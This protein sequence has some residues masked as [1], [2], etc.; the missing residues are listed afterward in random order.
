MAKLQ[1][2]IVLRD[3]QDIPF[4]E[5]NHAL[6]REF[7]SFYF[8]YAEMGNKLHFSVKGFKKMEGN[9]Y[10]TVLRI[11]DRFTPSMYA[12]IP[13]SFEAFS[14]VQDFDDLTG[15][16]F[17]KLVKVSFRKHGIQDKF[18]LLIPVKLSM[19][20]RNRRQNRISNISDE[21]FAHKFF[22]NSQIEAIYQ[23][24]PLLQKIFR[25]L[26]L[27][28]QKNFPSVEVDFIES[29]E[30][31][32]LELVKAMGQPFWEKDYAS[33]RKMEKSDIWVYNGKK[34][35]FLGHFDLVKFYK[36]NGSQNPRLSGNEI[37]QKHPRFK[38]GAIFPMI[39]RDRSD[40]DLIF[41][42]IKIQ[43]IQLLDTTAFE[44]INDQLSFAFSQAER[45]NEMEFDIKCRV[46]NFSPQGAKI[47]ILD[48]KFLE[49]ISK[50]NRFRF[51]FYFPFADT[52]ISIKSKIVDSNRR[53][54]GATDI[55]VVFEDF[56]R[57]PRKDGTFEDGRA[58]YTKAIARY[59]KEFLLE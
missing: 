10:I 50:T 46:L 1:E 59:K 13:D 52:D 11:P 18:L 33:P 41:G 16:P 34:Y 38:C 55:G 21:I 51:S 9:N 12:Q 23:D 29:K 49:E 14:L 43:S 36:E 24:R 6:L 15:K 45:K 58:L 32:R 5:I 22:T 35:P 26:I 44:M 25:G 17:K 40:K 56:T 3:Y 47:E 39:Y 42:Y 57:F 28:L 20:N 27:T 53:M 19:A 7:K 2:K 54:N 48:E 4:E 30:T 37:Y 31:L 8:Y